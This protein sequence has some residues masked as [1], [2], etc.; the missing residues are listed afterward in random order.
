MFQPQTDTYLSGF[1]DLN[2]AALT[3]IG[4]LVPLEPLTDSIET[5]FQNVCRYRKTD[6]DVI[7]SIFTK[8]RAGTHQDITLLRGSRR[9]S[10]S[11]EAGT[12]QA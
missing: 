12:D 4:L 3:P 5:F 9:E 7:I 6:S 2:T 1:R 8:M 11:V 10:F